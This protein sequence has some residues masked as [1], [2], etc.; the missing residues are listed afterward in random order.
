MAEPG[1]TAVGIT[2][3][4]IPI[5]AVAFGL[6]VE[7]SIGALAGAAVFVVST[8]DAGF[9][10]RLIYLLVSIVLG[11]SMSPDIVHGFEAINSKVFASFLGGAISVAL[12]IGLIK[13]AKSGEL[14]KW[15]RK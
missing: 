3:I 6:D 10:E 8:K 15:L 12:T 11:Y 4:L 9:L 1:S 2:T 5:G 14:H 13:V 7:R